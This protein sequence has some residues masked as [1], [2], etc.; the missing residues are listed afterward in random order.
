L[1]SY[2]SF[3]S[4]HRVVVGGDVE[5]VDVGWRPVVHADVGRQKGA[6]LEVPVLLMLLQ[7][8]LVLVL[9]LV[10]GSLLV[11][12]GSGLQV[13]VMIMVVLLHVVW[14][15]LLVLAVVGGRLLPLA[16]LLRVLQHLPMLFRGHLLL[17]VME[18]KETVVLL[19][20]VL[21]HVPF[22]DRP[23]RSV[24]VGRGLHLVVVLPFFMVLMLQLQVLRLTHTRLLLL[25]LEVTHL[26]LVVVLL[27]V[28][29][30]VG[31]QLPLLVLVGKVLQAV[32]LPLLWLLLLQLLVLARARVL[33][34]WCSWA[35]IRS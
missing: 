5:V 30:V 22:G 34:C 24:L 26:R 29:V 11:F 4:G 1:P 19:V 17:L 6:H 7:A 27:H 21:L 13:V 20:V 18:G 14:T 9:V 10:G 16:V 15:H 2:A 33:P 3:T 25:I 8:L 23:L 28:R 12:V 31:D 32:I 35:K